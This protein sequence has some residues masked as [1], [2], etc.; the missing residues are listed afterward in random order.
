MNIAIC[1][2]NI[3]YLNRI[4]QLIQPY[5]DQISISID[6]F[7]SG[8]EFVEALE[9]GS[10][11]DI[12]FLDIEMQK[13]SG[14][15]VA[16][17]VR[18]KKSDAII[19]FITNYVNYVSDTF[20]LGA[21]QFLVKPIDEE[22]FRYDFDR[23]LKEYKARHQK[24][25]VKWRDEN[26]VLEY[27]EIFYIESYNRHLHVH[28]ENQCH[29]CVGKL[30]DEYERLMP[31]HFVR[32]HQGF[33]ININKVKKINKQNVILKNEKAIPISRR[34]RNGFMEKFTLYLAGRLV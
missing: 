9:R 16:A 14:L 21:F 4:E 33:I 19:I 32:C 27:G 22:A 24:Y 23:A 3:D 1:D 6:S 10:A 7:L 18:D 2:D 12:I 34:Y 29:E 26:V 25:V 28:T 17:K 31:Y 5:N 8:E 30:Q 11:Y 20:R 15:D 13:M